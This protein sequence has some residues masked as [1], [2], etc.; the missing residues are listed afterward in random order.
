MPRTFGCDVLARLRC[1]G[2]L[3]LIALIEDASVI[4]RILA[5]LGQPTDVPVP[6]PSRA[7]LSRCTVPPTSTATASS[8][9]AS[10]PIDLS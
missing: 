2:R 9:T 1:G 8:T 6:R 7:W 10:N 5:H 4:R 3:R